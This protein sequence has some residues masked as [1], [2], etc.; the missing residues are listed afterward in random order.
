MSYYDDPSAEISQALYET[1]IIPQTAYERLFQWDISLKTDKN[2]DIT[3]TDKELEL[4]QKIRFDIG[5][6][7]VNHQLSRVLL[8][9]VSLL[10]KSIKLLTN[11][12][13]L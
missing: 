6:Q 13:K 3:Y 8:I 1:S 2:L 9:L 11:S 7:I 12:C 5:F 4:L 10:I